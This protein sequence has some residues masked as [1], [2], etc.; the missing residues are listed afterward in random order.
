MNI[1]LFKELHETALA[2]HKAGTMSEEIYHNFR[3]LYLA[4]LSE[5]S[6]NKHPKKAK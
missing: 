1:R 6:G 2:M 3:D 5:T 4:K